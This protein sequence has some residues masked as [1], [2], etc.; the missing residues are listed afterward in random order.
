M[1]DN[2]LSMMTLTGSFLPIVSHC[3]FP[4]CVCRCLSTELFCNLNYVLQHKMLFFCC[5]VPFLMTYTFSHSVT[6]TAGTNSFQQV[7]PKF[8]SN[9]TWH[10]NMLA[11]KDLPRSHEEE[12][13][14]D[15]RESEKRTNGS[16]YDFSDRTERNCT[17]NP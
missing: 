5:T 7:V 6:A 9:L 14:T 17:V 3:K 2:P 4:P 10:L 11:V 15:A 8:R 16:K 1:T 13:K 12:S